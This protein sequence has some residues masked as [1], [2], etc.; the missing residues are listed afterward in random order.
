MV[1]K[2]AHELTLE[3]T[4]GEW[5]IVYM[6]IYHNCS[7]GWLLKNAFKPSLKPLGFFLLLLI[8]LVFLFLIIR[9]FQIYYLTIPVLLVT[10]FVYKK[11]LL[12]S[13][14]AGDKGWSFFF[15]YRGERWVKKE[16]LKLSDKYHVFYDVK[17]NDNKGNIDFVVVCYAGVFA[18]EV[19]NHSKDA[20]ETLMRDKSDE[21]RAS[22]ESLQVY[23]ELT[24][25]NIPSHTITPVLV[26]ADKKSL[27]RKKDSVSIVEVLGVNDIFKFFKEFVGKKYGNRL[28]S[29]EIKET[30]NT[31]KNIT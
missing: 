5:Y 25:N 8:L 1:I 11:I 24:R 12:M 19:K 28:N 6:A 15:G 26:R 22:T 3:V 21:R 20:K 17:F 16:L 9:E 18:I 31:I 29:L 4:Q 2:L 7:K 23:N 27:F 30:V 14:S 10:F 13:E